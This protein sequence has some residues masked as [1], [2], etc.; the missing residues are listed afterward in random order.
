MI[1]PNPK[2]TKHKRKRDGRLTGLRLKRL[3]DNVIYRD[4]YKC[5]NPMCYCQ[6][7]PTMPEINYMLAVHHYK[8]LSQGGKDEI[9]N[10]VTLCNY[11]H[12]L[13][14]RHQLSE[15]FIKEYLDAQ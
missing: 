9:G 12:D 5:I 3:R 11:C 7:D 6:L 13:V 1:R 15:D 14:H 4:G 8:K 10:L 2:P